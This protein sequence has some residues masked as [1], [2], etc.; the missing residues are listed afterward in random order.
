MFDYD[1]TYNPPYYDASFEKL[2]EYF[3]G[4]HEYDELGESVHH[5]HMAPYN[6]S[7]SYAK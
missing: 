1:P 6:G 4:N 5:I 7:L 2:Y 3:E